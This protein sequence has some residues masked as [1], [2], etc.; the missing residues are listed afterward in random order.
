MKAMLLALILSSVALATNVLAAD[1]QLAVPRYGVVQCIDTNQQQTQQQ[2][3][4]INGDWY[5][6]SIACLSNCQTS[7]NSDIHLSGCTGGVYTWEVWKNNN[8]IAHQPLGND[9]PST[10]WNRDDT[11]VVKAKC[12]LGDQFSTSSTVSYSQDLIMLYEGWA[13][14]LPTSPISGTQ[15]CSLNAVVD[16]YRGDTIVSSWM[17]PQ[18]GT[19]NSKPSSTYSSVSDMPTNWKVGDSYVF[20][21][22]W[23]T[24]IADISLTYDKN[25]NAYWCGGLMGNRQIYNVNQVTS[26]SGTCYAIPTS[27]YKSN[28]ECCFPSDCSPKGAQYTCNPDT[29]ACEQTRWCDSQLDCDQVFGA[30]VCQDKQITSWS[31]DTSQKWG[32]HLG[33]CVK[34]TKTVQQCSSDCTSDEYYNEQEGICKPLKVLVDCPAGRCCIAGGNYKGQ[35]CQSGLICCP[36]ADPSVGDCEASCTQSSNSQN[37]TQAGTDNNSYGSMWGSITENVSVWIIVLIVVVGGCGA[38]YFLFIRKGSRSHHHVESSHA[39][40]CSKC[41]EELKAGSKFCKRCGEKVRAKHRK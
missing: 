12:T 8:E 30:G 13:G 14:T 7:G 4:T 35:S 1:C 5:V 10:S 31:C 32:D 40:T 17:D 39:I 16:N 6:A 29:W 20:V 26:K 21:K 3:F 18:T 19:Q 9:L 34:T 22:D 27:V 24:G 23:Q 28:I 2:S 11:F 36:S 25:N 38:A 15:G 37:S 41:G 33:T